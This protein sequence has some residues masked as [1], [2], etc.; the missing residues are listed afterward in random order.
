MNLSL[1]ADAPAKALLRSNA[2]AFLATTAGSVVFYFALPL[3]LHQGSKFRKAGGCE[4]L[5][6][7]CP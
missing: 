4:A 5:T 6:R 1:G 3:T 2:L 7:S